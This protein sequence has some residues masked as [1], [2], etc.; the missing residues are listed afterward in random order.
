M[1]AQQRLMFYSNQNS[2]SPKV[3]AVSAVASTA[4]AGV[5]AMRFALLCRNELRVHYCVRNAS[6][7]VSE[8]KFVGSIELHSLPHAHKVD[9][10]EVVRI[11]GD[12]YRSCRIWT[13]LNWKN[14]LSC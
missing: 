3:T 5:R 8:E 6:I 4:P 1:Q 10:F 9:I 14:M 2:K 7:V 12:L 13:V 11:Q